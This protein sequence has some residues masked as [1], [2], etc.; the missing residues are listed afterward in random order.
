MLREHRQSFRLRYLN[1]Y[2]DVALLSV[3]RP[4]AQILKGV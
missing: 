4:K 1:V 2:L 3:A